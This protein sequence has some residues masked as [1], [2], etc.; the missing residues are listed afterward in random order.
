MRVEVTLREKRRVRGLAGTYL[1][2][3][4]VQPVNAPAPR[5]ADMLD[6]YV[7]SCLCV[8]KKPVTHIAP[9]GAGRRRR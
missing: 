5:N 1:P 4:D 2:V 3:N 6:A 7:S 8:T 9:R